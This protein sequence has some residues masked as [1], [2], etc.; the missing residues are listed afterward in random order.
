MIKAD[1]DLCDE[2]GK[3]CVEMR[4]FLSYVPLQETDLVP[5]SVVPPPIFI[6]SP[7]WQEISID[8]SGSAIGG[9]YK[10]HQFVVCELPGIN[11]EQLES[12]GPR[13]SMQLYSA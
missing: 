5:A 7:M 9:E 3:I 13:K 4:G 12:L 2:S 6:A 8:M 11:A 10:Q 1:I